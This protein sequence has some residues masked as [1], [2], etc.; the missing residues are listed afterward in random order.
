MKREMREE[1]TCLP[2]SGGNEP[3]FFCVCGLV[4][5]V[6]K[7]E[8]DVVGEEEGER[9]IRKGEKER[10]REREREKRRYEIVSVLIKLK[11]EDE[12]GS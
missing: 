6:M 12:D 2:P 8:K 1:T 3:P 11:S 9:G 5:N 4:L 10:E 7:E